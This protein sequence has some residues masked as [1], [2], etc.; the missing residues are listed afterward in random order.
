MKN[1][2]SKEDALAEIDAR[3]EED[4]RTEPYCQCPLGFYGKF[5]AEAVD[6]QV[7]FFLSNFS[8][9]NLT[10]PNLM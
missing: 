10:E 7:L 3:M 8:Q 9:P 4:V 2:S 6:V 1:A 5:C